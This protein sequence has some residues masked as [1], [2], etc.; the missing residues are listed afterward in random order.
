MVK[1]CSI[2]GCTSPVAGRGWCSKHYQR[3]VRHG[4]PEHPTRYTT[5]RAQ[6]T[7]CSVPGCPDIAWARGWCRLHWTRWKR[8]GDPGPADHL[9]ARRD[10]ES[11]ARKCSECGCEKPVEDFLEDPR[12]PGRRL[13]LCA[14]CRTLRYRDQTRA[15]RYGISPKEYEQRLASQGGGCAVCLSTVRLCID[16]DHATGVIRGILCDNCN[17]ALGRLGDD[18]ERIGRLAA[19]VERV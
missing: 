17:V 12:H 2:E 19:Y 7:Q 13:S 10:G 15:R 5:S 4:D 14:P 1:S 9:V 18:P 16:H 3:W 8:K 11:A 6:E